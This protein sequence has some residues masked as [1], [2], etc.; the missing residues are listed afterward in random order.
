MQKIKK[1]TQKK[2]LADLATSISDT[3]AATINY[4]ANK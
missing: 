2:P 4:P 1:K 3:P